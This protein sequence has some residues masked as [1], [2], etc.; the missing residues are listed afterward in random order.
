VA[1]TEPS[2]FVLRHLDGKHDRAA[3]VALLTEWL[4]SHAKPDAKID[5]AR[6]G[7]YVD[8]LLHAF[9]RGALLTA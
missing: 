5:D 8:Q 2:R 9:A 6:S 7:P 4:K 1:L 3:L